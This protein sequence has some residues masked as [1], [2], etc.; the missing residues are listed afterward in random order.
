MEGSSRPAH[1][2]RPHLRRVLP[3]PVQNGDQKGLALQDPFMLSDQT[4][5][6][7]VQVA[8]A[9]QHFNGEWTLDD[10]ATN[11]KAPEEAIV[12]LAEKLDEVGLLWGPTSSDLEDAL[13]ARM[14][15]TGFL[16]LRQSRMLGGTADDAR[17]TLEGWMTEAEDPELDFDVAGL[18]VPRIDY[19]AAEEVYAGTYA[20]IAGASI[21]RVLL[22]GTNQFGFG[23][24]V[25]GTSLGAQSPLGKL[26]AD[27]D[28]LA[29]LNG[30]LDGDLF[31]DELDHVASP[32][33]EMQVPWLQM[34]I[35]SPRIAAVLVPDPL[36][37]APLEDGQIATDAFVEAARG[38]LAEAPGRSL[39]IASGDLSH[40]GPQ[41]GEPRP[42]DEQRQSEA[43]RS[44]RDLLATFAEGD[45]DRFLS[46]VKWNANANRWSGVGTMLALLEI[47]RPTQV[48][49]IDYHHHALDQAGSGVV[50]S[51]G[52]ALGT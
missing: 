7:P 40:I 48:E 51:A 4:M 6:V 18:F 36:S 33:V 13:R 31:R 8:Q 43:E 9:L 23:D 5:V 12:G 35:G 29:D 24:G 38:A 50:A 52:L 3:R 45:P 10:I 44:D 47:L 19:P 37:Q 21:D 20:A 30:R 28:F 42:I 11:L 22:I 49:L 15:E 46:A 32:D 17:S 2:D 1:I 14:H 39:V 27:T 16:P 25:V 41:F 26:E 34:M